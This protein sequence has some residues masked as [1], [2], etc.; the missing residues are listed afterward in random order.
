MKREVYSTSSLVEADL[1]KSFLESNGINCVLWDKNI[2]TS[3]PAVTFYSGIR[4]VVDEKDYEVAKR[5]IQ[6]YI[7]KEQ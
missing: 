3:H 7:D 4:V 2:A 1:I 6:D 5:I